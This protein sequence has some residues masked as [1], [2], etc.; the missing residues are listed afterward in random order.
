MS[1][2]FIRTGLASAA[3]AFTLLLCGVVHAQ[4][5]ER[6]ARR[7]D[8]NPRV[9]RRVAQFMDRFVQRRMDPLAAGRAAVGADAVTQAR[10]WLNQYGDR[11]G[12]TFEIW[13][14]VVEAGTPVWK[15][16]ATFDMATGSTTWSLRPEWLT[17]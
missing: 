13:T 2:P 6:P 3:M 16:A 8:D 14:V 10:N 4:A 12:A 11:G 9:Q 15:P 17:L 1:M 5:V 7:Q